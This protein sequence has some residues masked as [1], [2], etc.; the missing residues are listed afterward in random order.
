M[1]L[2]ALGGGC[3]QVTGEGSLPDGSVVDSGTPDSGVRH[4]PDPCF[5]VSPTTVDFG[6][7]EINTIATKTVSLTNYCG[8]DVSIVMGSLKGAD[9]LLFTTVPAAGSNIELKDQE[10]QSLTVQYAPLRESPAG[11]QAYFSMKVCSAGTGCE[12]IVMLRGI[13]VNTCAEVGPTTL[14]F[15]FT[16][17]GTSLMRAVTLA[18]VCSQ[19]IHITADP[20]VLNTDSSGGVSAQGAFQAGVGFPTKDVMVPPGASLWI[21]VVFTPYSASKFIGELDLST[22]DPNQPNVKIPLVGNGA[23][24]GI[25]CT[26][27]SLDFGV[28]PV[29]TSGTLP[30]V[31]TNVGGP[32]LLIP[33]PNVVGAAG[34]VID[35]GY[36][37]FQASF[38]P[39]FPSVGLAAGE[40]ATIIVRFSPHSYDRLT[41]ALLIGSNDPAHAT[42]FIWLSGTG[43]P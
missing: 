1:T 21:P 43:S 16:P 12:P 8:I 13:A 39:P 6:S 17:P 31:C 40:S 33:D 36:N 23:A 34:L 5:I 4:I 41:D 26:P 22:D 42:T 32:N 28:R 14:D 18:N 29:G 7:V 25:S 35:S 9:P 15:G 27:S 2:A 24:A 10:T 30:V 11:N 38:D 20:A 37:I 3:L 19:P